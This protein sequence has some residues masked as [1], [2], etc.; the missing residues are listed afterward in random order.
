MAR[1]G[2]DNLYG[3][4]G[5]DTID[6]GSGNDDINSGGGTDTVTGGSGND[7]FRIG[8]KS[9]TLTITDFMAGDGSED[10][11]HL[12]G[13]GWDRAGLQAPKDFDELLA[14][15]TQAGDD[16]HIAL[17]SNFTIVLKNVDKNDLIAED[18]THYQD[19]RIGTE[20]DDHLHDLSGP[21][22]ELNGLGGDDLIEG[23]RGYDTLNGG[24]GNDTIIGNGGRD[25]A[26]G[27]DGDDH[28][29][30]GFNKDILN[31]DAGNDT[32]IGGLG[33]DAIN[34]GTGD[35]TLTGGDFH[36]D[37]FLFSANNGHDTV[38][39]FVVSQDR[40]DLSEIFS[41][42]FAELLSLAVDTPDGVRIATGVDAIAYM[43]GKNGQVT[44]T[45]IVTVNQ[46]SSDSITL[47][48]VAKSDLLEYN[49]PAS[50]APLTL[51]GTDGA[52][53]LVGNE[54]RDSIDGGLGDDDLSG[55]GGDDN[56][57]SGGGNDTINGGDGND[58]I[59]G[60]GGDDVID[61]GAGNDYINSVGSGW[62]PK[63]GNDT[64]TTGAG[65]DTVKLSGGA[66][67]NL[68]IADFTAGNGSVDRIDLDGYGW[69]R[70]HVVH[71]EGGYSLQNIPIA[72]NFEE[73][74]DAASQVGD[75]THIAL[76]E[77]YTIVLQ[78]V[79]MNDLVLRIIR[80]T[81]FRQK[82]TITCSSIAQTKMYTD[83]AVTM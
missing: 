8:N 68:T 34:G 31:G 24:T 70:V 78:N 38:T 57:R 9:G 20:G 3:G 51:T 66:T 36:G 7:L 11:I 64:V 27:G 49:F 71:E 35:D 14:V 60:S 45:E 23:S 16:T 28:I 61:G 54:G 63:G 69:G 42:N 17:T 50:L 62:R 53:V 77:S 73:L 26:N 83:L 76:S 5:N 75:D 48:G 80:P 32:I 74:I 10:R 22:R 43:N 6:G 81:L 46:N 13:D 30:G 79:D 2:N 72:R 44:E 40:I 52:D 39:D 12:D 67:G 41:G 58:T 33:D 1:G 4:A 47:T 59:Y 21:G 18:F 19:R 82:A 56:I 65:N 15:S 37:S 55:G 29:T 25:V